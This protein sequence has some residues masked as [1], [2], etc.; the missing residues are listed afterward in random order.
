ML[1]Q[2]YIDLVNLY[3]NIPHFYWWLRMLDDS[4]NCV[5]HLIKAQL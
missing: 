3:R 5:I 4:S 2:E 1:A